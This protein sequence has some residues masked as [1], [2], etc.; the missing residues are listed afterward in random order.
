MVKS[1]KIFFIQSKIVK[2][3]KYSLFKYYNI[4][5]CY[6]MNFEICQKLNPLCVKFQKIYLSSSL[7]SYHP[8]WGQVNY[9]K[10]YFQKL[11]YKTFWIWIMKLFFSPKIIKFTIEKLL[12][13]FL[14]IKLITFI[15]RYSCKTSFLRFF[16]ITLS[17]LPYKKSDPRIEVLP[18]S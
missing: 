18:L 8:N 7:I 15:N 11:K 13:C 4:F 3:L 10:I 16:K 5:F 1:L 9:R 6:Q 2:Y 12:I 17:L 14:S